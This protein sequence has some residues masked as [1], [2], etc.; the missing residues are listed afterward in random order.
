MYREPV[1]HGPPVYREPVEY[2]LPV[3][4]KLLDTVFIKPTRSD[5]DSDGRIKYKQSLSVL[6]G[7]GYYKKPQSGTIY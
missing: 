7:I 6:K 1:E 4:Q 2:G 3:N 5:G